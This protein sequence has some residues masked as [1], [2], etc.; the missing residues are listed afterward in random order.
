MIYALFF[1]TLFSNVYANNTLDMHVSTT[2]H[3]K[4]K[5]LIAIPKEQNNYSDELQKIADTLKRDFSFS[6]QFDVSITTIDTLCTKKDVKKAALKGFPVMIYLCAS[7]KNI[8]WRLYNTIEGK[9]LKGKKY[10]K[11]GT[12]IRGWAHSIA[13]MVWPELTAQQGFF[14]S[15]IAYCKQIGRDEKQHYKHIYIADYDGSNEQPL[16]HTPTVNV[17]PRFNKDPRN[18][19]VFYSQF[20]NENIELKFIDMHKK[21][22]TASTFDGVNMLPSFSKDGKKVAYCASKGTGNCQIYYFENKKLTKI[23]DN[24]GNNISPTIANNGKEIYFCSDIKKCPSIYCFDRDTQSIKRLTSDASSM[25]PTYSDVRDQLV[26]CKKIKGEYQVCI[27]D[28]KGGQHEQITFSPGQKSECCWSPCGNYILYGVE[29]NKQQYL[30]VVAVL[31]KKTWPLVISGNCT[32]PAW[33][34]CYRVFPAVMP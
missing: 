12:I 7:L 22:R 21:N 15:R 10:K 11:K 6:E 3:A 2:K 33:S 25:S 5:L 16:V 4:M 23:T 29:K 34:T 19:L 31:S 8:D 26:Y 9:M 18:C 32:Y 1:L 13:D 20:T 14:S 28:C 24:E 17:G 30:E 27:Y